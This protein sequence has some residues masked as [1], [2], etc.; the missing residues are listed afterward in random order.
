MKKDTEQMSRIEGN[1]EAKLSRSAMETEDHKNKRLAAK[2]ELMTVLQKLE[3]T[4]SF[5]NSSESPVFISLSVRAK[6]KLQY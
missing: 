5:K 4:A 1:L 6:A 2:H 3:G